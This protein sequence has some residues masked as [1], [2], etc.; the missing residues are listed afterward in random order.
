LSAGLA[1]AVGGAGQGVV[2]QQEGHA[3]F[4]ELGVAFEHAVAM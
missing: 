3:V 1:L 4:A 2:V